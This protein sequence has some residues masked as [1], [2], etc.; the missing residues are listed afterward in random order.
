MGGLEDFLGSL[1]G[2][3][4]KIF[5]TAPPMMSISR[6]AR[7]ISRE[8]LDNLLQKPEILGLGE[9]YW[10][11]IVQETDRMLPLYRQTLAAGK[12]LEGHSAGASEKKLMAYLTAG[13][14]SCHEPITAEEVLDRVRLGLHVMIREGSIRRDLEA[15]A[16]IRKTGVSSRRLILATDG[17]APLD[18]L[19]KG[20][21]EYVVQK[22]I[23]CGF[24]P[25]EAIQM[26]T[27]NVAEHFSLDRWIGGIGPGRLADLVIVP[28]PRTIRASMVISNG[29]VI[30][31]DGKRLAA[32][33]AHQ[34]APASRKTV[35]LPSPLKASD[36][37]IRVPEG[38]AYPVTVRAMDLVTDLVTREVR[39]DLP[40]VNGRIPSD[41][42]RGI[43]KVA[44]IDRTHRPGQRFVG[45][46]R[47]FGLT[48]GAVASSAA[49][50]TSDII[51]VGADDADMAAAVNRIHALQGGVV[52]AAGG[53]ITAELPLPIFGLI[54]ELCMED[55]VQRMNR[56]KEEI[57]EMGFPYPDPLL[58]LIT[59]TGQAIPFLRICE[60]GL[61]NFKDG[62]ARGLFVQ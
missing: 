17:V 51:V 10:Q 55:L 13:I 7:G 6:T 35:N 52:A 4:V 43:L 37:T 29:K 3:P 23:D 57:R 38:S 19:E 22:A 58:T 47:G 16:K 39:L 27:L 50:D 48:R 31:R 9:S 49:W 33:R 30:A 20:C 24:D 15:I 44:A 54:S 1:S 59:L 26:A 53:R 12:C 8:A 32:P 56:L 45:V 46:I 60:E 36:F 41:P 40:V 42:A 14:S 61:V 5:A 18:L 25:V 28:D 11:S 21:M 62:M 2:Q 34:W